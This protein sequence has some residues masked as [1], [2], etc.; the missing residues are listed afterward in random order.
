MSDKTED[1]TPRRL[2]KAREE[3]DSGTSAYA[4]QSVAFLVAVALV[5]VAV[6]ALAANAAE[7]LRTA[8]DAVRAAG[9]APDGLAAEVGRLDAV[10]LATTFVTLCFP[11]LLAAGVAGALV[12]LLQTGGVVASKRLGL[13][14]E[15]LNPVQGMKG[16]VSGPR[17]FSVARAL[18]AGTVV[19]WLAW[20]GLRDCIAD[21]AALG[22]RSRLGWTGAV[23]SEAAGA[24]A[25][26]A[27][28]VGLALAAVDVLVTR[29]AWLR[30]LRM[31]KDEVRREHKDA[32]GD[33]QVK[34]ARERAYKELL[35]QATVANVRTASVV[36]VNPTHL[37]CALRYDSS[38]GG[39]GDQAPVVVATGQGDL[40][41]RILRAARD[42]GVP[43]VR[44]VPLARALVEL[45]IG[46]TIPE[47]LYEA[48]AE[49]L[50]EIGERAGEP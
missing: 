47:T 29:A 28:M 39:E 22:G 46:D 14:L 50:R 45:P 10:H 31:S 23:V 13:K 18:F 2:R 41:A 43:V 15:R 42:G 17:L 37:A 36:V 5:P 1:P 30:R 26:R 25:W 4:A 40:A 7:D 8:F 11:V 9:G 16:L 21:I 35:A 33:P 12:H 24:L 32:E 6:R 34:A 44:D 38:G 27:G 48:V 3:G 20:S 19:C 49:I